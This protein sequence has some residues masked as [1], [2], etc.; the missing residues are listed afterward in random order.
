MVVEIKHIGTITILYISHRCDTC[1][2]LFDKW[3]SCRSHMPSHGK[4]NKRFSILE[5]GKKPTARK[6]T[7]KPRRVAVKST[8]SVPVKFVSYYGIHTE[9]DNSNITA[10]VE[11]AGCN[12]S[13]RVPLSQYEGAV[14]LK[15]TLRIR[16]IDS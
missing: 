14:N 12:I 8:A 3:I 5:L 2:V 7:S 9:Y 15:P 10:L 4:R 13:M 16:D 6:S 1:G 11:V